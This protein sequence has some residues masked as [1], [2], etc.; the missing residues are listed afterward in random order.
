MQVDA[1]PL[2][3]T[4]EHAHL[5]KGRTLHLHTRYISLYFSYE[6]NAGESIASSVERRGSEAT[7]FGGKMVE[8]IMV[9]IYGGVRVERK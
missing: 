8:L 1:L 5:R 4:I 3:W 7:P 9:G 2:I 6:L